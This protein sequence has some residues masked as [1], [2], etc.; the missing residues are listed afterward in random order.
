MVRLFT[1]P[2]LNWNVWMRYR[3]V[4]G[5]KECVASLLL[6]YC[7]SYM[8]SPISCLGNGQEINATAEVLPSSPKLAGQVGGWVT[9]SYANLLPYS[10]SV[11]L[12]FI[13]G[14]GIACWGEKGRPS[15]GNSYCATRLQLCQL[16]PYLINQLG[17]AP[18]LDGLGSS[19]SSLSDSHC[20]AAEL[21][22]GKI[23]L[24]YW[25]LIWLTSFPW[26]MV[27]AWAPYFDSWPGM[28]VPS[29]VTN[30]WEPQ[31]GDEGLVKCDNQT[32]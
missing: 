17:K 27:P 6:W 32:K 19:S 15:A 29:P 31:H 26:N 14:S 13:Q 30:G 28:R 11:L 16:W 5:E 25:G 10:N 2:L 3:K 24:F 8:V 1:T 23:F 4:G 21:I 18:Q 12:L 22:T 7:H 9:G 20:S